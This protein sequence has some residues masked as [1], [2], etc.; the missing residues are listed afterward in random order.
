MNS[1]LRLSAEAT[2][3]EL[4]AQLKAKH[5]LMHDLRICKGSFAEVGSWLALEKCPARLVLLS[6]H[7]Q[8]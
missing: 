3:F 2:L 6:T 1:D 4:K 8:R 5:G 7:T